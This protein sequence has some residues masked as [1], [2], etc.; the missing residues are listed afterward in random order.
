MVRIRIIGQII[1]INKGVRILKR[2]ENEID[3]RQN[4]EQSI[5]LNS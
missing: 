3:P 5:P 2:I 1:I 4:C